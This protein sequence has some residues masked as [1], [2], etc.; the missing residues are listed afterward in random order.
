MRQK[1]T[2]RERYDARPT[3]DHASRLGSRVPYLPSTAA[4]ITSTRFAL[5]SCNFLTIPPD[6]GILFREFLQHS[7]SFC[8]A[9]TD[10]LY[11]VSCIFDNC[12][13]YLAIAFTFR[14]KWQFFFIWKL[15]IGPNIYTVAK[16]NFLVPDCTI[17]KTTIAGVGLAVAHRTSLE[18]LLL[19]KK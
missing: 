9:R 2:I 10:A 7:R 8:L 4:N 12:I 1:R 17:W 5:Y 14:K 6:F 13:L 15:L 3:S 11:R 19:I 16:R 18:R